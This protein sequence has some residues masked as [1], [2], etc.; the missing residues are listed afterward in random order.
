MEPFADELNI[1]LLHLGKAKVQAAGI[2]PQTPGHV[3]M[4]LSEEEERTFDFSE[5]E[6]ILRD[7]IVEGTSVWNAAASYELTNHQ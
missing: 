3:R 4:G 2:D 6:K 7:Q 5:R 1:L